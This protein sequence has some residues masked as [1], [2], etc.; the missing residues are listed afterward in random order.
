M[1]VFCSG[2]ALTALFCIF[3]QD[4]TERAAAGVVGSLSFF[5]PALKAPHQAGRRGGDSLARQM[6]CQHLIVYACE[7]PDGAAASLAWTGLTDKCVACGASEA[8][9]DDAARRRHFL[10][11]LF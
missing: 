1:F 8:V 5:A 6:W 9:C 3:S 2:H 11:V 7:P 10:R 4:V